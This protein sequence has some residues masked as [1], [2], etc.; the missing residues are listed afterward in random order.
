MRAWQG[1]STA[2][3]N[4]NQAVSDLNKNGRK[5][6]SYKNSDKQAWQS[7]SWG[8][9]SWL[10]QW[11]AAAHTAQS[12]P[13]LPAVRLLPLLRPMEQ[14]LRQWGVQAIAPARQNCLMIQATPTLEEMLNQV[15]RVKVRYTGYRVTNCFTRQGKSML[16]IA[17]FMGP[18]TVTNDCFVKLCLTTQ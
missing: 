1:N 14:L 10:L 13:R 8:A 16:T 17:L 11:P 15:Q 4:Q 12:N 5:V 2:T 3:K 18:M 9:G 7:R 6:P